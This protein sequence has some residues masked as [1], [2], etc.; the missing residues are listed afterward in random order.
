MVMT[1]GLTDL[2]V[3]LFIHYF[4]GYVEIGTL[5]DGL[6]LGEGL[7]G[8]GSRRIQKSTAVLDLLVSVV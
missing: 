3:K 6:E 2:V 8:A 5:R 1:D 7:G 4:H